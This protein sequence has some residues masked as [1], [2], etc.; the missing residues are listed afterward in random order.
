MFLSGF[1]SLNSFAVF[2]SAGGGGVQVNVHHLTELGSGH[3][4]H[5]DALDDAGIVDQN[6]DVADFLGDLDRKSVV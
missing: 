5:G 2:F 4:G 1:G 3:L 6:V